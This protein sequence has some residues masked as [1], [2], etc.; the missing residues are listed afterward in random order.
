MSL[1]LV[2]SRKIKIMVS[3]NL[4][5]RNSSLFVVEDIAVLEAIVDKHKYVCVCSA[6]L[7]NQVDLTRKQLSN[8]YY[9]CSQ[10]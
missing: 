2:I 8:L 1:W 9:S 5:V 7:E 4:C 6:R 10:L 3:Q